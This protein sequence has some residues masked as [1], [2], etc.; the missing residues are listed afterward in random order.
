[1][2]TERQFD[3][4]ME[5]MPEQVFLSDGDYIQATMYQL[6]LH[7]VDGTDEL[8]IAFAPIR[9]RPEQSEEIKKVSLRFADL[10]ANDG[11]VC[12]SLLNDPVID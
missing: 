9:E 3:L 8:N 12:N 6:S 4:A 11:Y 2:I 5:K 1:M 10:V 7:C